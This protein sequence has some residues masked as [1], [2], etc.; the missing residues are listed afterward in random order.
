[1]GYTWRLNGC[2]K[3]HPQNDPHWKSEKYSPVADDKMIFWTLYILQMALTQWFG[4]NTVSGDK[5]N[6]QKYILKISISAWVKI[7]FLEILYII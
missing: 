3:I 1:M 2:L 4:E 5:I 6:I 7:R